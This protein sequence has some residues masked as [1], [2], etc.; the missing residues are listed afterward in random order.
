MEIPAC[1]PQHALQQNCP[2]ERYTCAS[3]DDDVESPQTGETVTSDDPVLVTFCRTDLDDLPCWIGCIQLDHPYDRH[4]SSSNVGNFETTTEHPLDYHEEVAATVNTK[5]DISC[6]QNVDV[7]CWRQLADIKNCCVGLLDHAYE[8]SS[9]DSKSKGDHGP[10]DHAYN[11]QCSA[12]DSSSLIG[13]STSRQYLDHSYDNRM[14][15]ELSYSE[16]VLSSFLDH[17]YFASDW[18]VTSGL[19]CASGQ[20]WSSSDDMRTVGRATA[21]YL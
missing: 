10:W 4:R 17:A 5:E 7:Q 13:R 2:S 18:V 3:P 11:I 14:S 15:S 8:S 6:D 19:K 1:A 20:R 16:T 12:D 21:A 9:W